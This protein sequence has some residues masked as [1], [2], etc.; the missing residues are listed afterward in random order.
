MIGGLIQLTNNDLCHET[1]VTLTALGKA[2]MNDSNG[3]R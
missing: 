1:E 3:H 2:L